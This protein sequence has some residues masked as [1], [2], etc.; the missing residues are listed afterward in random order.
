MQID[1]RMEN[2]AHA[3]SVVAVIDDEEI[4]IGHLEKRY[5]EEIFELLEWGRKVSVRIAV[6]QSELVEPPTVVLSLARATRP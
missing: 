6:R 4:E 2:V 5:E 3:V 1:R